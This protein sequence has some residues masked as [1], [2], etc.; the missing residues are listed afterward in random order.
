MVELIVPQALGEM[1]NEVLYP[2]PEEVEISKP[3]G[4]ASERS[5]DKLLA[6]TLKLVGVADAVP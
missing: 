1:V 2:L 6:E 5:V 4:A 3:L